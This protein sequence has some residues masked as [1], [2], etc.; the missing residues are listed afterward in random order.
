MANLQRSQPGIN[1]RIKVTA[2]EL[3]AKMRSKREVS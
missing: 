2:K 1:G 3:G